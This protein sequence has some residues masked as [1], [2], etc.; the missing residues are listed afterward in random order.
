[1]PVLA[2]GDFA[3]I[4]IVLI[5]LLATI[6]LS[7]IAEAATPSIHIPLVGNLRTLVGAAFTKAI[8]GIMV[9]LDATIGFSAKAIHLTVSFFTYCA[10]GI[11]GFAEDAYKT[12]DWLVGTYVPREVGKLRTSVEAK[13]VTLRKDVRHDLTVAEHYAAREVKKAT[14]AARNELSKAEHYAITHIDSLAKTVAK[15]LTTAEHY[16]VSEATKAETAAKAAAT[17]ALNDA[18]SALHSAIVAVQNAVTGLANTVSTDVTNLEQQIAGTGTA[19]ASTVIGTID[20]D[21]NAVA[22]DEWAK[23]TAQIGTLEGTIGTDFTDVR[24]WL[25]GIPAEALQD[26]AGVTAVAIAGV[27]ILTKLANDCIV[28]Q[29]RNLSGL[30]NLLNDLEGLLGGGALLAFLAEL[31]SNPAGFTTDVEDV[32]GPI[33]DDTVDVVRG[34]LSV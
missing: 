18:T 29:C 31:A 28:P 8:H 4:A 13:L 32:L 12:A 1:M 6:T 20:Q 21:I 25:D 9:A 17:A 15:D 14:T 33:A 2:L 16:A 23:I 10:K 5:A 34:L 27:G 26:I 11:A 24:A 3:V 19:V 30:G 7:K 22:A